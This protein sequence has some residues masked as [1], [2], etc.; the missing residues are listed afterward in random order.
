METS[1][2]IGKILGPSILI[3][4]LGLMLNLEH[5]R[6]VMDDYGKNAALSFFFGIIPLVIGITIILAHN[7]WVA[8]WRAL[9]TIYGWGGI[10]K[11]LWMILF[12]DS[13]PEFIKSYQKN[14]NI[15]LVHAAGAVVLGFALTYFGYCT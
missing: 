10:A 7:V 15:L 1:L 9:I 6:K 4:G 12:P 13:V 2:Y 11:G 14:K 8:D 5:Y 3:V